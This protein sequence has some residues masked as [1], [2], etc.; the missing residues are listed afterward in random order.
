M[1]YY[2]RFTT[3]AEVLLVAPIEHCTSIFYL[4]AFLVS[5]TSSATSFLFLHSIRAMYENSMVVAAV[6]GTLWLA[7]VIGRVDFIIL[8]S[9][10]VH[11]P[12][13]CDTST[14]TSHAK[15]VALES[16]QLPAMWCKQT[17][18]WIDV[19]SAGKRRV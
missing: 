14:V 15:Y 1:T 8:A 16:T 13:T 17:V 6:F 19:L 2:A 12:V 18:T 4:D 9:D 5:V 7:V 11:C 3:H 10:V